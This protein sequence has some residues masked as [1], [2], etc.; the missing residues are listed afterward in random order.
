M[1]FAPSEEQ[2]MLRELDSRTTPEGDAVAL[3]W[4]DETEAVQLVLEPAGGETCT[5]SVA[6]DRAYDA[7][8][9]PWAY[10]PVHATA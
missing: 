7:F 6:R 2:D 5:V 4:D 10:V 8:W 3:W 1:S 9:H